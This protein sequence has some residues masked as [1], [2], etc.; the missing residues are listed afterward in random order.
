MVTEKIASPHPSIQFPI[1]EFE[2]GIGQPIPE[3]T[4]DFY[5]INLLMDVPVTIVLL[6]S[7]LFHMGY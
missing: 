1:G 6:F 3:V 4:A 7:T 5:I 2:T